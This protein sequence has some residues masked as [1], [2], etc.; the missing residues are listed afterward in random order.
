MSLEYARY[1]KIKV[2]LAKVDRTDGRHTIK[3]ITAEVLLESPQFD[4]AYTHGD[5]TTTVPT[6]T[7][8]NTM[9][10]LAKKFPV[11][12]IEKF[13]I[14]T[15]K[16]FLN[17]YPHITKVHV[18]LT[19]HIWDRI[20]INNVPHKFAFTKRQPEVRNA[21]VTMTRGGKP[22]VTS[23]ILNLVVLK[24]TESAFENFHQ[25]TTQ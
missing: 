14:E 20:S 23:K 15:V 3:E 21:V 18:D 4:I 1:G 24:T 5:N 19:E 13:G 6:D 7:T 22:V 10:V 16:H 9:Y 11:D 12:P 8:R 2:N 25:V 17:K